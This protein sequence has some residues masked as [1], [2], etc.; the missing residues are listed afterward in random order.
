MMGRHTR[1]NH[2]IIHSDSDLQMQI[3]AYRAVTTGKF[4]FQHSL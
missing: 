4:S 2:F 1:K 3:I